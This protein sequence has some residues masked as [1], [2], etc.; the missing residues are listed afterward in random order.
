MYRDYMEVFFMELKMNYNSFI[1]LKDFLK[2]INISAEINDYNIE[3]EVIEGTLSIKGKYLKRDNLT[4]EYFDQNIPFNI[5]MNDANFEIE[6][7]YC[8]N[9]EYICIESRGVDVSFDIFVDYESLDIRNDEDLKNQNDE[10]LDIES[11]KSI[12]TQRIDSLLENTLVY[13]EDNLPTEEII[14]RGLKDESS[15]L[16]VCYYKDDKELENICKNNSLSFDELCK[17]NKKFN[18][19]NLKRVI[20]NE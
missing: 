6:D 19:N 14:I 1:K 4:D 8:I 12:E 9:L 13:K 10:I 18:F 5:A 17:N 16:K 2:L 15:K 11:L 7:I 3:N 20:I